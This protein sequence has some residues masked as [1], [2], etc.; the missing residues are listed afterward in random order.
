MYFIDSV[1]FPIITTF[2]FGIMI[3]LWL[4]S[5]FWFTDN[6]AEK[7]KFNNALLNGFKDGIVLSLEDIINIYKWLW[8]TSKDNYREPLNK[9][10]REFLISAMLCKYDID[11]KTRI[12][13]KEKI[14]ELIKQNEQ[15]SPF[16]ELPAHERN[17]LDDLEFYIWKNDEKWVEK[18]VDELK[19]VILVRYSEHKKLEKINRRSVPLA[20]GWLVLT[21]IFWVISIIKSLDNKNDS[22]SL[23]WTGTTINADVN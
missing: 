8:E 1:R 18:K 13:I 19:N 17:I 3:I 23:D 12:L 15:I 21:L 9:Y 2:I 6:K 14:S 10:L 11:D 4:G 20:I 5:I 16:S 7:S 22:W